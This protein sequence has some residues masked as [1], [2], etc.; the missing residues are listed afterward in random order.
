MLSLC[1]VSFSILFF[2][3]PGHIWK[4]NMNKVKTA[5]VSRSSCPA[6]CDPMDCSPAD[7]SVHGILQ[8]R[9]L[10]WITVPFSRGSYQPGM[11]HRSLALQADSLP[12]EPPRKSVYP[13]KS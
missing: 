6:L 5:S 1:M 12:S 11:E 10:K 3:E 7:S 2:L 13:S 8:A 4:Y 9:I